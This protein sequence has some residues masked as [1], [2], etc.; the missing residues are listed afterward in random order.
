MNSHCQ[1]ARPQIPSISSSSPPSGAPIAVDS[2]I[3]AM[4]QPT[5]RA[6]LSAGNQKVRYRII[7]GKNPASA[8]PSSTRTT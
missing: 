6:R 2:G 7:P 5:A 4:N 1:P 8:T 3:A